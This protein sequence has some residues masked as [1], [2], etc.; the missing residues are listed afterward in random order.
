MRGPSLVHQHLLR[1]GLWM[2]LLARLALV[3]AVLLS[4]TV[5]GGPPPDLTGPMPVS[6]LVAVALGFV[7]ARRLAETVWL[8]NLGLSRSAHAGLLALGGAIG[9][10]ALAMRQVLL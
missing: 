7:E 6:L 8:A 1:R 5:G 9:E 3:A 10:A 4:V 2:W